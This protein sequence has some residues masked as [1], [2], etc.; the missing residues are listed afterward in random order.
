MAVRVPTLDAWD[1]F[2]WPLRAAMPQAATEVEQ[3]GYCC[4]NTVDLGPVMLAMEFRVT[5]EE[6]AYLCAARGLIFKGSVLAYNPTRDEAEWVPI[7]G[8]TNDLSWVEERIAVA[9][10]NFVP[11]VPQEVDCIVELRACRLLAWADDSPLEEDDEQMQE[12]D[13]EPEGDEHEE[14]EEW[15]EEDPADLEEQGETGLEADPLRQLRE[16]GSIMDDEQP[17]AFNDPQSDSDAT[18]GGRS[19]AHLTLQV[20]WSPQD[21]VEVHAQDSEVEA[22]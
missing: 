9:L 12:E 1:Q 20:L 2:I 18:V 10:A 4:G 14:A 22:L 17:L 7:C 6:C 15:E 16:W 3:Y 8:V 21:A 11:R 5:N 13:D 19:P